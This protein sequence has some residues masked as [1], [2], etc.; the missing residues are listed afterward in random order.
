MQRNL[1]VNGGVLDEVHFVAKTDDQEDLHYLEQLLTATPQ[2]S[3]E[4]HNK[5]EKGYSQMY[6]SCEKGKVYVKIDDDVV[7]QKTETLLAMS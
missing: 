7:S 4:F 6:K 5:S 3:A 2:F 1:V